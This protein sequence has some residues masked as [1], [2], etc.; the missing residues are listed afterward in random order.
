MS[1]I[2]RMAIVTVG[3]MIEA[4]ESNPDG[5]NHLRLT[6]KRMSSTKP[7]QKSGIDWP[8]MVPMLAP[9]SRAVLLRR[10]IHT[11]SGIATT[12]VT[13]IAATARVIV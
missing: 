11:P 3:R 6:A 8:A 13:M 4:G 1:A 10:A 9:S 12:E 5:A 7:I 2:C